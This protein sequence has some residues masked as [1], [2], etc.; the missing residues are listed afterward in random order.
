MI[1]IWGGSCNSIEECTMYTEQA[2]DWWAA[3]SG[4]ACVMMYY[5]VTSQS[6]YATAF[7]GGEV[8]EGGDT[9]KAY[10]DDVCKDSDSGE[11]CNGNSIL[12]TATGALYQT[13]GAAAITAATVLANI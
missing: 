1:G 12:L 6:T 3:E 4:Y 13:I 11:E 9:I 10:F 8:V 2:F 5:D 7:A